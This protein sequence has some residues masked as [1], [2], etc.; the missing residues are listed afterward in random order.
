MVRKVYTD[1]RQHETTVHGTRL[2]PLEVNHDALIDFQGGRIACHWH[3]EWEFSV[4]RQGTARYFLGQTPCTLSA[5]QGVLINA[6]VPHTIFPTGSE[7]VCL[8]TVIA[9]PGMICGMPG[10]LI[11]TKLL[12]PFFSSGVLSAIPLDETEIGE[13]LSIEA[14]ERD[15]P[16]AWEL[17]CSECLCRIIHRL[18]VRNQSGLHAADTRHS[19]ADL[20]KLDI[21]LGVLQDRWDEP[22][23]LSTLAAQIGSSREGCCRFFKRMTGQTIS[24]YLLNQRLS[25]AAKLLRD[26]TWNVTQTA[27]AV[28][29][30]NAGRFSAA[31]AKK[32]GCTPS[33]YRQTISD[34]QYSETEDK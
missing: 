20:Q 34:R 2:F 7:E 23:S 10:G 28:G 21:I 1:E 25:Q 19:L 24:Q 30:S 11:E 8:L 29:F 18:L 31:F 22:L 26:G 4:V 15:H 13:L 14:M 33:Q 6:R 27:L 32:M 12:R 3:E 9:N 16:F 5:G 17:G